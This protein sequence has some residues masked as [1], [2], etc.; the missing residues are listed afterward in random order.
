MSQNLVSTHLTAEQWAALDQAIAATEAAAAPLLAVLA[1]PTKRLVRMGDGSEAFCRKALDVFADNL[2]L[3]PRNFDVEEM[4]RDL[5][6]HDAL[7]QRL[8][9]LKRLMENLGNTEVA[10]GSDAMKAALEGYALLKRSGGGAGIESLCDELGERFE[11]HGPRK[12]IPPAQTA[13]T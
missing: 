11:N 3:L 4:R 8:V 5:Q 1:M 9:R 13:A 7:N 6:S 10:L 12:S 2:E